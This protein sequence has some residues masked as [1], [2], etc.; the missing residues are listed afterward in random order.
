MSEYL[1]ERSRLTHQAHNERNFHVFYYFMHGLSEVDKA[2][3]RLYSCEVCITYHCDT[4]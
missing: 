1:L 2:S 3:F 4:T